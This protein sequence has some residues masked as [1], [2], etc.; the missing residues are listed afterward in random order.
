M[1]RC[2]LALRRAT[3]SSPS[4]NS[5][6]RTA[7]PCGWWRTASPPLWRGFPPRWRRR[8]P[9]PKGAEMR[10]REECIRRPVLALVINLVLLLGGVYA[11][12]QL[13]VRY[14]PRFE[15]PV[16]TISTVL[17]GASPEMVER[18]IT[19]PIERSVLKVDGID[20]MTSASISG[21]SSIQLVF[22]GGVDAA[23]AAQEVR[24]RVNEVQAL[25]PLGTLAPV[26]QQI[27]LDSQPT[28]YIAV[29]DENRSALEVTEIIEQQLRPLLSLVPGVSGLQVMGQR[30]YAVRVVL[31]RFRLGAYGL[32]VGDVIATLASQNVDLPGGE[33][34]THGRRVTIVARTSLRHPREFSQL[35]VREGNAAV[36]LEDVADVHIGAQSVDTAVRLN[37]RE[38]LA[39]GL[40]RQAEANPVD[41]SRA[42]REAMPRLRAALPPGMELDVVYDDAAFID[43]SVHEVLTTI[44]VTV[45]LVVVVVVLFL[46]SLRS[47]LIALVAVPLS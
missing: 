21:L 39:V 3:S 13:P 15:V 20:L 37:G 7:P 14:L 33:A 44:L 25:L 4:A 31:D 46:G 24:A 45:G 36:R 27:S 23:A 6:S 11:L 5:G 32:T 47:S 1:W 18:T 12:A 9:R 30:T 28:L 26:V 40:Q 43:A 42:V 19:T 35:I 2:S 41:I 17:P 34:S 38:A 10:L 29:R 8:Q 22:R 16:G